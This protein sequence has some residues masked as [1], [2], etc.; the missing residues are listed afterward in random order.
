MRDG[1]RLQFEAIFKS[2]LPDRSDLVWIVIV[3]NPGNSL[4]AQSAIYVIKSVGLSMSIVLI[5][6]GI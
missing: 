1:D 5:V 2:P 3:S 6:L 4:K